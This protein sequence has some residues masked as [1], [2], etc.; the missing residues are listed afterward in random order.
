[1]EELGDVDL[2]GKGQDSRFLMIHTIPS[3]SV[4]LSATY[5]WLRLEL[6]AVP[7]TTPLLLLCD[8]KLKP[9]ETISP[10]LFL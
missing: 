4:V 3:M 6:S 10:T 9:S 1:M 8:Y 5:L 2:L 7:A